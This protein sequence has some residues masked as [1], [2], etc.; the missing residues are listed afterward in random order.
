VALVTADKASEQTAMAEPEAPPSSAK[1]A[2]A[3]AAA[4]DDPEA[5]LHGAHNKGKTARAH[6]AYR[7]R[8]QHA[9]SLGDIF[10]PSRYR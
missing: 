10:R 8:Q 6:T 1:P 3:P 9:P 5:R 2:D 7:S 4:A